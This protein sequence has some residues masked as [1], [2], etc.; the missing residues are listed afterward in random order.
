VYTKTNA[1]IRSAAK[2]MPVRLESRA[3]FT[4]EDGAVRRL[5]ER[6]GSTR[7]SVIG[8]SAMIVSQL[9]GTAVEEDPELFG[10]KR[11]VHEALSSI[12]LALTPGAP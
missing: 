10:C 5:S 11:F 9:A 2:R 6:L 3:S 1:T 8:G 12:L 7:G 4:V